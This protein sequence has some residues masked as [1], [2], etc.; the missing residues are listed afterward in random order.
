MAAAAAPG[1]AP[2]GGRHGAPAT[3]SFYYFESFRFVLT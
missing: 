1:V 2:G 3:L